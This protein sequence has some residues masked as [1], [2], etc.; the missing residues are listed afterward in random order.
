MELDITFKSICQFIKTDGKDDSQIVE[1][2]DSLLGVSIVCA[3]AILGP[4]G[5]A[6]LPLLAAKNELTKLGQRLFR[7]VTKNNDR[8]YLA[9]LRRMQAAHGLLVY[10]AFFEALDETIPED[11]RKGIDLEAETRRLLAG[12]SF[13][14]RSAADRSDALPPSDLRAPTPSSPLTERP[15]SFPQ[16]NQSLE[17]Q[18]HEYQDL[19]KQLA[20]SFW[21]FVQMLAAWE[22]LKQEHKSGFRLAVDQLP[23]RAAQHFVAQ[24][25]ELSRKFPDFAIWA[26]L[27]QHG[28]AQA[29]LTDLA[30][31]VTDYFQIASDSQKGLDLGLAKLHGAIAELQERVGVGGASD[32][33]EGL[34]HHYAARL[35]DPIIEDKENLTDEGPQLRFPKVRDAF[36][37]QAFR[38]TRGAGASSHLEDEGTWTNLPPR[39]DLGP[40]LLSH[41]LSPYSTET[42]LLILGHPGSGKSLLTKVLAAQ[43]AARGHS[44]VRVPLREANADVSIVAQVEDAIGQITKRRVDSWATLANVFREHPPVVILDGY[45]ELLQASGKVYAGYLRDVKAFQKSEAEQGRPVRVIVTSRVTLIDKVMVPPGSTVLRLLEFDER[46]QQEWISIWN[47]ANADYFGH[48][49]IEPF[50]LPD[51]NQYGADKVLSLARQPLLLLMLALYDSEGNQLRQSVALDRTRL[52]DALLRRF[53][54]RE[55]AKD[56]VFRD[57]MTAHQQKAAVDSDMRRLG[58]AAIGMYNRRKIH[59]LAEELEADLRFFDMAKGAAIS[60]GRAMSQADL[61]LGSFFFVHRSQAM[62]GAA[63][64][65]EFLHNTFGEFLTADFILRW[66]VDQVQSLAALRSQDTLLPVF[67]EKLNS[68]DGLRREWFA[69]LIYTPLFTRPVVLEMIRE[70]SGHLLDDIG[71]TRDAFAGQ[72]ELVIRNQI[73]RII[74]KR[75]MPSIMRNEVVD[76]GFRAR[77]GDHP[78]LGH[79]AVYSVNLIILRALVCN[80]PF[81]VDESAIKSYEDGAR[82]WDRLIH[83]WHSWFSLEALDGLSA[84]IDSRRTGTVVEIQARLILRAREAQGRMEALLN[85]SVALADDL[86]AGITGLALSEATSSPLLPVPEVAQRLLSERIDASFEIGLRELQDASRRASDVD[87]LVRLATRIMTVAIDDRPPDVAEHIALLFARGLRNVMSTSPSVSDLDGFLSFG[88]RREL[89]TAAGSQLLG[90]LFAKSPDAALTWV[91]VIRHFSGNWTLGAK[92]AEELFERFVQGDSPSPDSLRESPAAAVIWIE[93]LREMGFRGTTG[94][95]SRWLEGL[96]RADRMADLIAYSP[97]AALFVVEAFEEM[98]GSAENLLAQIEPDVMHRLLSSQRLF[99]L[100]A[101]NPE[102]ATSLGRLLRRWGDIPNHREILPDL[103]RRI[104][105][106]AVDAP[107]FDEL[108]ERDPETALAII[109]LVRTLGGRDALRDFHY[110]RVA[111]R[112]WD[113]HYL[114]RLVEQ[115]PDGARVAF[116]IL[117]DLEFHSRWMWRNLDARVAKQLFDPGYLIRLSELSPEA[118][119]SLTQILSEATSDDER[120]FRSSWDLGRVESSVGEW[121]TKPWRNPRGFAVALFLVRLLGSSTMTRKLAE[122]VA[123]TAQ[124]EPL[125]LLFPLAALDNLRWLREQHESQEIVEVL[126]QAIGGSTQRREAL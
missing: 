89:G 29:K 56:R 93:V 117:G 121:L 42:P 12:R 26:N 33:L 21:R 55:R 92:E 37:P 104:A 3:P 106:E 114:L 124:Q 107:Y 80:T 78:L 79:L 76:E 49:R 40:Y 50:R 48:V 23:A 74:S 38:V 20:A 109:R 18:T 4:A 68:P 1:A 59:I 44:V 24:Y 110:Q 83:L 115:N 103:A 46:R 75:A 69:S 7:A 101:R 41:L 72:M 66:V 13:P 82:P 27:H 63:L 87:V 64:A 17:E 77:F 53:V 67:F 90:R 118:A 81:V 14:T 62:G 119:L 105:L 120:A 96:C 43:L 2:V 22:D 122:A 123:Q 47:A 34:A 31:H 102:A 36:V 51:N 70:W 95:P 125:S 28:I 108:L 6:V 65:F 112:L 9:R 10:T 91:K 84:V 113:G 30:R 60:E 11:L 58:V 100:T 99:F 19:W 73:D 39:N 35:D 16:P 86:T 111:E 71:N 94:A 15:I 52:Y 57:D 88:V 54:T 97:Q 5:L 25:V 8:N 116:Q 61:L 45:D 32:I 126:T 85:A 98:R